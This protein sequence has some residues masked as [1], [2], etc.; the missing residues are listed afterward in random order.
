MTQQDK[1]NEAKGKAGK[2]GT[3]TNSGFIPATTEPKPQPKKQEDT[4]GK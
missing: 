2:P 1:V 4:N 3:W